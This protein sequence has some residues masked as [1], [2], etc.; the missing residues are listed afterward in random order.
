MMTAVLL[1]M[2]MMIMATVASIAM[3][4]MVVMVQKSQSCHRMCGLPEPILSTIFLAFFHIKQVNKK[5]P[6][7]SW[8]SYV[9]ISLL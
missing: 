3:M 7:L 2:M 6:E 9:H 1:L 5:T 4:V 8:G